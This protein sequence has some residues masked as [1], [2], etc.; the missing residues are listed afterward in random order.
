MV[1]W[2]IHEKK[3]FHEGGFKKNATTGKKT[4]LP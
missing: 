4:C 1:V 2:L 3:Q